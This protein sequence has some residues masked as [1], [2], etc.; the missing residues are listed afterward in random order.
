MSRLR[1]ILRETPLSF[2]LTSCK[3]SIVI[4][5]IRMTPIHGKVGGLICS[6]TFHILTKYLDIFDDRTSSISR[7]FRE[8]KVEHHLIQADVEKRPDIPGLTPKGFETWAT[9]MILANPGREYERLQ[10]AVLNMPINNPDDKKE[11]FP[12]EL[13]RRLFPEIGDI[14]IREDIENR[15]MVHCG[16]DLP[17]I[18]PEERNQSAARPT[19][20]STTTASPTER[21][22]SYERG[23]PRPTASIP[24]PAQQPQ[25]RPASAVTDD[26]EEEDEPI[27]SVPIER[28]RKPYSANPG[29]GKVYE[30]SGQSRSHASSFSTSRPSDSTHKGPASGPN[31]AHRMSD[32]Y[33]RDPHYSRSGSGH[34]ADKRFS[35]EPRSSSQSVN[36]R[37]GGG[38]GG[39]DYRHSEGDLHGRDH[40]A[41]YAGLSAHDLSY[42]ESPTANVPEDDARKYH[43]SSRGNDEDYYRGSGQG[44]GSGSSYD[45]Y[46][47]YYR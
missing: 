14:E 39:G 3:S 35:Y 1:T 20:S 37:G 26:D 47:K 38:S 33:D 28:E 11:R 34:S 19:R 13:P 7:L 42:S 22:H 24:K 30:E 36:H 4:L 43:R 46:D 17:Y 12:K 32:S 16:V 23:R 6:S 2:P 44:G 5:M 41:R 29:I 18:T 25:P 9:L 8:I 15:M 31:P 45:K 10:K 21:T 40:A 27:P